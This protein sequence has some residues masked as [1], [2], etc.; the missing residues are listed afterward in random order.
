[1]HKPRNVLENET[2]KVL[3]DL[4]QKRITLSIA[5]DKT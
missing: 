4:K 5:E 2:P 1:M 3:R